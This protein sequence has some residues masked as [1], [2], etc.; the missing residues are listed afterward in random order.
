[1][2][3]TNG[4]LSAL[5]QL[6]ALKLAN[7]DHI[8]VNDDMLPMKAYRT[9]LY[10]SVVM[11]HL[12]RDKGADPEPAMVLV[13]NKVAK[14]CERIWLLVEAECRA[15]FSPEGDVTDQILGLTFAAEVAAGLVE[16]GIQSWEARHP[17]P[18][19]ELAAAALRGKADWVHNLGHSL[20]AQYASIIINDGSAVHPIGPG[21]YLVV[22][23]VE[24]DT[25]PEEIRKIA[26]AFSQRTDD[27]PS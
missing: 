18:A 13:A 15:G 3:T 4:E 8:E 24:K 10:G 26:I 6:R 9:S 16:G 7:G 27:K 12:M 20:G 25:S 17:G 19:G 22:L 21:T 14:T 1:M 2:T 11:Q 23:K 5:E